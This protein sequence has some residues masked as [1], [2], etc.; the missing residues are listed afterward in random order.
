[1]PYQKHPQLF[2]KL[3]SND[4]KIWRFMDFP[5]LMALLE[6]HTLF[7]PK[8]TKLG[9]KY[10]GEYPYAKGEQNKTICKIFKDNKYY[11]KLQ[12]ECVFINCWHINDHESNLLWNYYAGQNG[13]AIQSTFG[14]VIKSFDKSP[15]IIFGGPVNYIDYFE[16]GMPDGNILFPFIHK[17]IFFKEERELRYLT[18]IDPKPE[19]YNDYLSTDG[20]NI[21]VNIDMLIETIY[22]S[23]S[24]Q[25]W[26]FNLL[27]SI[28][29]RYNLN[30]EVKVSK[31]HIQYEVKNEIER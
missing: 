18:Y 3:L 29:K 15:E 31:L 27:K 23:P 17:P 16:D 25:P 20:K 30:K 22:L 8:S 21:N 9:S 11:N 26:M 4:S 2:K 10:E 14:R 7:F 12:K 19:Y 24:S 13:I 1:L 6:Y 5:Q 28:V